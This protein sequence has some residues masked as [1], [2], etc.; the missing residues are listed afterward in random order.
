MGEGCH[1][2]DLIPFL[3]G[4]PIRSLQVEKIPAGDEGPSLSDNFSMSLGMAD[5]SL[6]SLLYT[7]LGDASLPKERIEVHAGGA[8]LVLEDFRDLWIH[9]GGRARKISGARDKGIEREA[10]ALLGALRGEP[11]E[12]ISWEEIE[13]ATEWTIRAREILEGKG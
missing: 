11:S 13:A 9:A 1:F 4:S 3:A 10:E 12:L 8:S 5:G 2:V 6:G 7:S